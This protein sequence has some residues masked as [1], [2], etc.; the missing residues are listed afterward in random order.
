MFLDALS[1]PIRQSGWI[2]I[3]LGAIFSA[4]LGF[5]QGVPLFGIPVAIFS[6]GYFG[7]FYLSIIETTIGGRET[8]PEWPSFTSFIDDV[9]MPFARLFGLVL[10]S[11]APL[12]AISFFGSEDEIWF[13]PAVIGCL[14]FGCIYFPMAVVASLA[15][16]N[17]IAALPH[18][19]VPGIIKAS[20]L[21]LGAVGSLI[22]VL[23]ISGLIEA[24]ASK[25]P[26][27]GVFL[28]TA[29]GL[30]FMMFQG[31]MIGLTYERKREELG[32]E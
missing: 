30:Y 25:V 15:F 1:Y 18:V 7:A 12:I 20:P 32:W 3:L 17:I 26:Y 2:M 31:R 23:V 22:L 4:I 28:A 29:A 10:I 27:A 9:L 24:V 8:L 16:G 6:A 21:Y 11:F 13:W 14:L 19:V 5:M